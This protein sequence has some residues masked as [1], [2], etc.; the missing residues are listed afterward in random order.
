MTA[1][2]SFAARK[3]K[4]ALRV[5]PM[6]MDRQAW[7]RALHAAAEQTL[8]TAPVIPAPGSLR[9]ERG[10]TLSIDWPFFAALAGVNAGLSQNA[11]PHP[12]PQLQTQLQLQIPSEGERAVVPRTARRAPSLEQLG[13]DERLWAAAAG[14]PIDVDALLIGGDP[15]NISTNTGP[16]PSPGPNNIT[17]NE[18]DQRA[19]SGPRPLFAQSGRY[20]SAIEVYTERLLCAVHALWRLARLHNRPDWRDRATACSLWLIEHLQPDNAT[21]YPWGVHV[22]V[23]LA[24]QPVTAGVSAST[25][26][27]ADM[28][29]QSLLHNC[30][31][32]HG[33]ADVRSAWVLRDAAA[34]L[35]LSHHQ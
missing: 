20:Q 28:Y 17:S 5:A 22:L 14:E 27:A 23:D 8:G 13:F 35:M 1:P 16:G 25:A 3:P 30:Q 29:A 9:D 10:S 2:T 34:E 6:H 12:H 18:P 7:A 31:V 19:G 11:A 26:A 4:T 32:S 24:Q 15:S 21:N 33:R